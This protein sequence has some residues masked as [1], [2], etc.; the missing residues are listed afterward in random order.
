ML[1]YRGAGDA[2][3]AAQEQVLYER[4]KADESAQFITGPYRKLHPHD[5]NERQAVHEH[6]APSTLSRAPSPARIGG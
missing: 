5:N 3:M 6:E 4:L 1:A 2:G